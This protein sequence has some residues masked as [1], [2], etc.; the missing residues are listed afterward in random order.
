MGQKWGHGHR[1]PVGRD[2]RLMLI[3]GIVDVAGKTNLVSS[4]IASGA[5]N[6]FYS[7][8]E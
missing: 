1:A 7:S 8:T 4:V 5:R 2:F 6:P 3:E